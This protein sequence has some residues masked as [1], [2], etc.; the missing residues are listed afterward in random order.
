[1]AFSKGSGVE[2]SESSEKGKLLFELQNT[3]C[4]FGNAHAL[5]SNFLNFKRVFSK[6]ITV[7]GVFPLQEF[8]VLMKQTLACE[9]GQ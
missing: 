6:I 1:M 5:S 8:H 9:S 3:S 7:P 4:G 2:G